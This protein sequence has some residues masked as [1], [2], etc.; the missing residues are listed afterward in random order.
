MTLKN[1]PVSLQ[2]S[3]FTDD[4]PDLSKMSLEEVVARFKDTEKKRTLRVEPETEAEVF[5]GVRSAPVEL[6]SSLKVV[7]VR[8]GVSRSVLT[9]CMSR[10]LVDWYMNSLGLESLKAEFDTIYTKIKLRGYST[11]RIQAENPAKFD[12]TIP[13]E[14]IHTSISTIQ[15]VI[16]R[17]QDVGE[18]IGMSSTELLLSGMVWSLTTL[19]N[20]DWDRRC[21]E[22]RFIPES[23]NLSTLVNDRLADVRALCAKYQYRESIGYNLL[24][25]GDDS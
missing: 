18:I 2:P 21:I 6:M 8:L 1:R 13:Q 10:Q 24:I 3:T 15:W 9:K 14:A 4:L 11:L 5:W 7:S 25:Y 12:F 22:K 23:C 20:R 16:T 17:L 19:E